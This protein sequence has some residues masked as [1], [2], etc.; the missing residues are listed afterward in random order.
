[1]AE[2]TAMTSES[3]R[4]NTRGFATNPDFL[5]YTQCVVYLTCSFAQIPLSRVSRQIYIIIT[6][7]VKSVSRLSRQIYITCTQLSRQTLS[8]QTCPGKRCP[9]KRCPGKRCPGKAIQA[10]KTAKICAPGARIP[11]VYAS[12]I[13]KIILYWA[14]TPSKSACGGLKSVGIWGSYT[15][16]IL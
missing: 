3:G 5:V 7:L 1:M 8:R 10:F 4:E 6:I 2:N 13:S 16:E 11:R 9:G 15:R 12:T 14:L